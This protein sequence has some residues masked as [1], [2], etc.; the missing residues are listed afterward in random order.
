MRWRDRL[1]HFWDIKNAGKF[2]GKIGVQ[3]IFAK[4]VF[5]IFPD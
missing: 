1:A 4:Q 2:K 3:E 5:E